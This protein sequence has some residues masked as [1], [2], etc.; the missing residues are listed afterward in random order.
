M[1]FNIQEIYNQTLHTLFNL[2]RIDKV[3][4]EVAAKAGIIPYLLYIIRWNS[5]LKQFA[6]PILCDFA[7]AGK[8]TRSKLWENEG[9]H[10]YLELLHDTYWQVNALEAIV[11][12]YCTSYASHS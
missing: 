4:Q 11:S 8:V 1:C 7:H 5:P 6:L 10:A 9:L 2:C 12:W 3:R